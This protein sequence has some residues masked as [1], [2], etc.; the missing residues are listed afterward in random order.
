MKKEEKGQ[1]QPWG[2]NG[3]WELVGML[4]MEI[5]LGALGW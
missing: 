3:G 1:E 4:V 2:S 5:F